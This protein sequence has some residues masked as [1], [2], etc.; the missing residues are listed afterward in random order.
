MLRIIKKKFF[1]LDIILLFIF[2]LI[3][4]FKDFF[5]SCFSYLSLVFDS[6][7]P[8]TW[9]FTSLNYLFPY[10]DIYYP[11]GILFYLKNQNIFFSFIYLFLPSILF[12]STFVVFKKIFNNKLH[13]LISFSLFY[14]FIYK[15]SGVENFMRYGIISSIAFLFS[16]IFYKSNYISIK[17]SFLLGVLI[18]ITLFLVNDQGIYAFILFTFLLLITLVLKFGANVVKDTAYYKFLL[19]RLM[20]NILGIFLGFLPFLIFLILNGLNGDFFLYIKHI[21]DF[22][23]YAKTP[24]IPFSITTD[25]LF[26]FGSLFIVIIFLTYRLIFSPKK[27]S[28]TF[29]LELSFVFVLVLLE[30]KS[31]VRSIDKQITFFALFLYICFFS[32]LYNSLIKNK[33]GKLSILLY[34]SVLIL[35]LFKGLHPFTNY[36][37]YF[38]KEFAGR[39]L[40]GGINNFLSYKSKLC[41]NNNYSNLLTGKN[42]KYEKVKEVISKDSG[43]IAKIFDYLSDPVF[44]ALF[45]QEPPYYFTIFEASS[46]YAQES[47]IK[48]IKDKQIK[49]VIYNQNALNIQD[50]VPDYVRGSIL[51]KYIISNF[52]VLNRV[53]NF[54]ILKKTEEEN[55]DFFRDEGLIMFP[56]FKNYL[57]NIN[58][59][60]IPRSEGIYKNKLLKSS[61]IIEP[62]YSFNSKDKILLVRSKNGV[63]NKKLRVTIVSDLDTT[64][65]EFDPCTHNN[66]CIINLANIPI[67][68]RDRAIKEIN[69]DFNAI[70]RIMILDGIPNGIF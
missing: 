33:L 17:T 9:D 65:V 45:N 41:L 21:S 10:K 57:L 15:Y 51:F 52:S 36:N 59:G 58:L 66:L 6:Q 40:S 28:F 55:Y 30:Q 31:L 60:S 35:I 62:K 47:N 2:L 64:T 68:Y 27:L 22:Q 3:I 56:D 25:N 63:K 50:G 42:T 61:K 4:S 26:T 44:Y 70:S 18:G 39:I 5:L 32:D 16:F 1:S 29:F 69:Y 14:I 38:H 24:F 11:Y 46:L 53:D 7:I 43:G 67:F 23:L 13:S 20:F 34:L 48:F 8:L 54:I 12:T 37:L 49:Y 19:L